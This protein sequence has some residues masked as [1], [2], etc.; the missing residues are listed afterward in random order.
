[1]KAAREEE[2][3]GAMEERGVEA[4]EEEEG[5]A[6]AARRRRGG[7]VFLLYSYGRSRRGV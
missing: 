4:G 6:A 2:T 1:L 3:R 7:Q 5:M